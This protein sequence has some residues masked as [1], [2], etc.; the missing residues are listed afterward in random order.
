[1]LFSTGRKKK[2][3]I[4]KTNNRLY[5]KVV[6]MSKSKKRISKLAFKDLHKI[7]EKL[8]WTTP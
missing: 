3:S 8:N 2:E 7:I 6:K 1:M 5:E 4:M